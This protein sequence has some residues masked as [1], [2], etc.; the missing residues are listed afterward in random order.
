MAI[1]RPARQSSSPDY[2]L[3]LAIAGLLA[4][5]LIMVY[6]ASVVTAYTAYRN[7]FYF[8]FKQLFSAGIG[9]V[10]MLILMRVDY[11]FLRAFSVPAL[12]GAVVLLAA[13]LVPGIGS[14]VYGAQR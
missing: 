8:F 6:S 2:P 11:H 12:A 10:A 1:S 14:E 5:G 3:I 13:V 7:Q 4:F 9:L